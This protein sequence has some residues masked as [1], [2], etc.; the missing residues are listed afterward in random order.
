MKN[1]YIVKNIFIV[2]IMLWIFTGCVPY[3]NPN[4]NEEIPC[5]EEYVFY[6]GT[7][8][9]TFKVPV[10]KFEYNG[11]QY[12]R[13]GE[14]QSTCVVHDPDC[15]CHNT[16]TKTETIILEK[17]KNIENNSNNYNDLFNF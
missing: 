6:K 2:I 13:F 11:H 17:E 1:I 8:D 3:P 7:S 14:Y 15:K 10:I 9:G 4:P 5:V 16:Q 12:I